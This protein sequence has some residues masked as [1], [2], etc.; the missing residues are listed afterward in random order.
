MT[1][2]C[3]S[4]DCRAL[5]A[6]SA[7]LYFLDVITYGHFGSNETYFEE[8]DDSEAPGPCRFSRHYSRFGVKPC[9]ASLLGSVRAVMSRSCGWHNPAPY[10]RNK[11]VKCF[12]LSVFVKIKSHSMSSYYTLNGCSEDGNL[13]LCQWFPSNNVRCEHR[14]RDCL[15]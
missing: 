13:K 5:F 14:I 10:F 7:A 3:V 15:N 11:N 9:C 1:V 2:S 8:R 4:A 6:Q 12:L